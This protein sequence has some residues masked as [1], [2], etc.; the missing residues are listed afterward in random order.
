MITSTNVTLPE[1]MLALQLRVVDIRHHIRV[2]I[3]ISQQQVLNDRIQQICNA[4]L[5]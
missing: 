1:Q 2:L 3:R 4:M 5:H